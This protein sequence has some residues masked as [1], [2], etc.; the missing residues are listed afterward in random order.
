M[1]SFLIVCSTVD[2]LAGP[3]H[4]HHT[5]KRWRSHDLPSQHAGL[6]CKSLPPSSCRVRVVVVGGG[7]VVVVV[8]VVV[9]AVAVVA[10]AVCIIQVAGRFAR[11]EISK[12]TIYV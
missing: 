2:R 7:V 5:C 10:V 11:H 12:L 1:I 6:F 8:V 4:K 9:V 3:W